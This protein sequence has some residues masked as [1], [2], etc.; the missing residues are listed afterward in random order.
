LPNIDWSNLSN[1]VPAAEENLTDFIRQNGYHQ[2][3]LSPSRATNFLDLLIVSD[4]RSV[5]NVELQPPFATSDHASVSWLMQ[6]P[7]RTGGDYTALRNFALADYVALEQY[8]DEIDWLTMF[9]S[10]APY[11]VEGLWSIFK[12]TICDAVNKHVPLSSKRS[13]R[14]VRYP[15]VIQLALN[16]KRALWRKKDSTTSHAAYKRQARK[17]CKLLRQHHARIERRL[18]CNGSTGVF[19]QYVNKRLTGTTRK[20]SAPLK[21]PKGNII[22]D[23]LI[24][25]NEFNAYFSS[26]FQSDMSVDNDEPPKS[27]TAAT[28]TSI[29]IDFSPKV[30]YDA[31]RTA[32]KLLSSSPDGIPS[33][34]WAKVA[35]CLSFPAS[36]IFGCS[37]KFCKVPADWKDATVVPIFKK[38]DSSLPTN[39]RPI[40]LTCTV[41]KIMETI[42]RNN[43]MMHAQSNNII[44]GSQH[45]FLP[46]R[47]T[48]TQALESMFDWCS[49]V[50]L[51]Y[52]TDVIFIDFKK[53]F[54]SVPHA[55]LRMKLKSYNYCDSTVNWI[56]EFLSHRTQH[57]RVNQAKS[58]AADVTSGIVQ[59][60]VLGPYSLFCI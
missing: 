47:S 41:S 51:G 19:Y 44:S 39:Y 54:D 43:M 36:I 6:R 52:Y 14:S 48:S 31:M 50:E 57:V 46:S 21:D 37:Y 8:F 26:V 25:A 18:L 22:T 7:T 23:D 5:Y 55:K 30:V 1:G 11:D 29:P 49:A 4:K 15:R 27:S 60:G 17:C 56:S 58:S 59:G 3:V 20:V 45:G 34:F 28:S 40:S 24:K 35:L 16:K 38:G 12:K 53:A 13:G 10:V 42:V 33:V 32:K 9:L 2:M